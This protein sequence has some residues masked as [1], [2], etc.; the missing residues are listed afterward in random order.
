[1]KTMARNYIDPTQIAS[2]VRVTWRYPLM[3]IR[4]Q[5]RM[6]TVVSALKVQ[7]SCG[8]EAISTRKI[9]RH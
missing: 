1:M 9:S 6:V 3:A 5:M 2:K 7:V 8:L 4:Q